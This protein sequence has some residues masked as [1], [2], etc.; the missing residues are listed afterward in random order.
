MNL[1]TVTALR[2]PKSAAEIAEWHNGFA[3]LAGGTWLFSE[4]QPAIDTLI[5]LDHLG[6]PSLEASPLGSRSA[7][8]AASPNFIASRRPGNGLPLR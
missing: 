1:N 4:P 8:P 5:D 3:W 7:Q 2:H 6:W